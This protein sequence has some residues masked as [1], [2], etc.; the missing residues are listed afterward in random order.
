MSY[1]VGTIVGS[2]SATSINQRLAT[3]LAG[4]AAPEAAF[5]T[6]GIGDLPLYSPDYDA[7]YPAAA[8][9][10]KEAID[11]A[12]ALLIVTP[13]YNRS[14]PGVLKNAIDWASRPW[15][16]NSFNGKPVG[17]IGASIGA[18]GTALAQAH[19]RQIMAFSN[20]HTLGQPEGYIQFTEG[21]VDESG[22]VTDES[23]RTFLSS[24]MQSF[25]AHIL[26]SIES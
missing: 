4:L 1:T 21:L 26:S 7:D 9:E 12:D 13:E 19:L 8:R 16:T 24:W 6:I 18:M 23:V 3:A 20:A 10:F 15:G 22:T 5:V 14:I 17:I 25:H 11:T 2:I